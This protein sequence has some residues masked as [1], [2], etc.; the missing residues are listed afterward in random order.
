MP[1]SP[2]QQGILATIG[3]A[4]RQNWVP[5]VLLNA[6]VI[7]LVAS[8]YYVPAVRQLWESVGEFKT[9]W[10]Y[11]FSLASTIFA[12]VL[13]PSAVQ[14]LMGTLPSQGRAKRIAL[15]ALF[16]GYRGME[17]DL[18]YRFQGWLFGTGN[19]ALTLSKKVLFDQFVASPVWFVPTYLI[20]LRWVDNGGSWSRTRAALDRDFWL[21]TCPTV[22][23]TN[24]LIWIPAAALIYSLPAALQF[25]LFSLVM[26][27]FIV[28]V[29]LMAR[30]RRE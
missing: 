9:R 20:A 10:S 17:I 25:P 21:R 12:A 16:W 30:E 4:F 1:D 7:A 23:V 19:D 3:T 6:I 13:M 15:L 24:W 18:F 28:L 22:L 26:T 29:T 11:A 14:W 27:F 5:C 2:R 8:Y